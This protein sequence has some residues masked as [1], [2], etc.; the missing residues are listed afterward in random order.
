MDF[1]TTCTTSYRIAFNGQEKTDEIS[2]AGNHNTA[3]YWEYDTRLGRRWNLDPKPNTSISSYAAF[4]NNPIIYKD[5]LGDTIFFNLFNPKVDPM[6][7]KFAEAQ[8][9]RNVNDGVYVTMAHGNNTLI[10]STSEKGKIEK[11]ANPVEILDRLRKNKDFDNAYKNKDKIDL[12]FMSCNTGANEV[13]SN[14]RY[15]YQETPV[16]QDVAKTYPGE[17]DVYAPDG[18][19]LYSPYFNN[20]SDAKDTY[21]KKYSNN[22]EEERKTKSVTEKMNKTLPQNAEKPTTPNPSK[23]KQRKSN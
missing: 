16:A 8:V 11:L 2:G 3:L 5:V 23:Q 22:G 9:K 4:A 19:I 17:I 14:G 21:W 7:Y 10:E 6:F 12:I 18:Y 15:V 13:E 1:P 20:I